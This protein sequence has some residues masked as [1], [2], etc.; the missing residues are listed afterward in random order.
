[1][2]A[3]KIG[4]LGVL[5]FIFFMTGCQ[6]TSREV[7]LTLNHREVTKPEFMLYLYE[8]T[9]DFK[10]IGGDDIWETDFDGQSAEDLVKERTLSTIQ[11]VILTIQQAQKYGVTLTEEDKKIAKEEADREWETMTE[12]N[13]EK[14]RISKEMLYGVMEDTQLYKKVYQEVTKDY[15]LSE[16]DFKAYLEEHRKTYED[17]FTQYV[18][19]S[20]L[21]KDEATAK[22]VVQKARAGEDFQNLFQQYEIDGGKKNL[23]GEMETYKAS[24]E[25]IFGIEFDLEVGEVSEPLKKEEG[26]FIL[27]VKDK[28][29]PEGKQLEAIAR[30]DYENGMKKQIFNTEFER[31][32]ENAKIE[33]N[34]EVWN[35]VE[36]IP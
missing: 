3:W 26:Y 15:E 28:N 22:Q 25:S 35:Q 36:M 11:N 18:L 7:V 2:K 33:R 34:E 8:V 23:G 12:E 21:V 1:M 13:H 20:I 27:K 6:G 4:L 24:V 32:L 30:T 16:A 9:Q 31:W 17:A 19:G 5:L 29:V 10:L 14:I